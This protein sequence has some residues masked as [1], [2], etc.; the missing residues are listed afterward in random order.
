M[1]VRVEKAFGVDAGLL[2]RMQA[3]HA[4]AEARRGAKRIKVLRYS[5][6]VA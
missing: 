2:L 6:K 1:A 3:Q 5:A 4:L